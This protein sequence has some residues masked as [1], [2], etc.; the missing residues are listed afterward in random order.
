MDR[1]HQ[2]LRRLEV[3]NQPQEPE[4]KPV[5]LRCLERLVLGDI[6]PGRSLSW[7]SSTLCLNLTTIRDL[8][9]GCERAIAS[10]YRHPARAIDLAVRNGGYP[11][12]ELYEAR[13]NF[14]FD[15]HRQIEDTIEEVADQDNVERLAGSSMHLQR[16]RMIGF[17]CGYVFGAQRSRFFDIDNLTSLS[18]ESCPNPD[19]L[20]QTLSYISANSL[21]IPRLKSFRLRQEMCNEH[22]C[23][24]LISFLTSFHGLEHLS[25]LLEGL[26]PFLLPDYIIDNH[27]ATLLT[28]VWDQRNGRR[29]SANEDTTLR[30]RRRH[31]SI[32]TTIAVGCPRLVELGVTIDYLKTQDLSL[33][34]EVRNLEALR[35]FNIRNLP[36][37]PDVGDL[38]VLQSHLTLAARLAQEFWRLNLRNISVIG[39]GSI[40]YE[41]VWVSRSG[42]NHGVD[43][44]S[45]AK[46]YLC[47]RLYNVKGCTVTPVAQGTAV[48]AA[49]WSPNLRIFEPYWLG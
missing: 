9:L 3:H 11:D 47:P 10:A 25:L 28:L 44:L 35:T 41:D 1:H 8:T 6:F 16:L 5:H 34:P 7:I 19:H 30:P 31:Q 2:T 4:F 46:F 42:I 45:E 38:D 21:W 17:D 37:N 22:L 32:I 26:L 14:A 23:K 24:G 18:L 48:D 40:T 29:M 49:E 43:C 13:E 12:H 27:G 39:T 15:I 33:P 36:K 20:G